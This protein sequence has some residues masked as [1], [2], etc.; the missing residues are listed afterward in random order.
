MSVLAK[1][2]TPALEQ[3]LKTAAREAQAAGLTSTP[4]FL[5]G[6]KAATGKV[7]AF[8]QLDIDAFSAAIEPELKSRLTAG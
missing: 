1:T 3:P 5:I 4:S 2:Q 6:P 7:L 8:D